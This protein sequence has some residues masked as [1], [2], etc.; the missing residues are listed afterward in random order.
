MDTFRG[1][2]VVAAGLFA[3]GT[4]PDA[5]GQAP[6]PAARAAARA[7]GGPGLGRIAGSIPSVAALRARLRV[8]DDPWV[9]EEI[10]LALEE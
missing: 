8:V 1:L 9:R 4:A 7:P 5:A 2:A 3:F 10:T 6:E